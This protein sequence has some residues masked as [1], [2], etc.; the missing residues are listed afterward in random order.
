MAL[1]TL[2]RIF[3]LSILFN[4]MLPSSDVYSDV[5]LMYQTWRFQNTDSLEKAGCRACYGKDVKDLVVNKD[6]CEKHVTKN[7]AFTCGEKS[8]F[9]DLYSS[10]ESATINKYE[11]KYW[12]VN[13]SNGILHEGECGDLDSCCFKTNRKDSKG[14][15]KNVNQTKTIQ[16]HPDYL[17]DCTLADFVDLSA[18][19]NKFGKPCAL[20][21]NAHGISCA[22]SMVYPNIHKI[23]DFMKKNEE[24]LLHKNME[25]HG[26]KFLGA[27]FSNDSFSDIELV[28]IDNLEKDKTFEC[29][30]FFKP[31]NVNIIGDMVGD[32]CGLDSCKLHLDYLH[33]WEW[34][35]IHDLHSWS[36]KSGFHSYRKIGGKWE[37]E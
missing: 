19:S 28:Q 22:Y 26:F 1:L 9:L 4:M 30:I 31:K 14:N 2:I 12:G 34:N 20:V 27:N 35:G 36:L 8:S 3:V 21:G 25:K 23:N 24:L 5:F 18:V 37:N 15:K 16:I 6:G 10:L 7:F 13:R 32:D 11:N 33:W 17:I 29:G